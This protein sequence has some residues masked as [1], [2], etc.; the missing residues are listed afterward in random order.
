M[1][2]EELWALFPIFL[3]AHNE[4]WEAQYAEEEAA[5]KKILPPSATLHHIGSTAVK[6]IWAKPIIDILAEV[7]DLRQASAILQSNGWTQMAESETRISLNKGYLESG[8]GDRVFHLHLRKAG[9][10]DELYFRD[11][12]NA[13]PEVAKEYEALKLRLWKQYEHDRDGYTNAKTAFVQKY[14]A[15]AKQE[16]VLAPLEPMADF[17]N[18]RLKGYEAHQLN[19]IE[20]AREFYPFTASLLPRQRGAR[21]LDLGCGTG[22]ELDYYFALNPTARVVGID[23][24]EDMLAILRKK[25]RGKSITTI[26]ASYFDL[27]FW[28]PCDAVVSVESLHHYTKDEKIPLYRK[29]RQILTPVGY[30]ILTDYFAGTEEQEALSR[31]EYLR[32]KAEQGIE[33]DSL[34]HYDTPLTLEHE[35]EALQAAGFSSVRVLRRWGATCTIKATK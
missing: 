12:L 35:I 7:G 28:H 19:A 32:L 6:G 30:F 20:G 3:T 31:Q 16:A 5:L 23:L 13:H 15:L 10:T 22:L 27:M 8:F 4:A 2:L 25:F 34:Y 24:A 29:V 26:Q 14:T 11:Y 17:F 9:D 1:T 18:T 21:V 33:D